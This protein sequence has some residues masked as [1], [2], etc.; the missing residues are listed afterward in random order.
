MIGVTKVGMM[1]WLMAAL[2]TNCTMMAFQPH[3][4]LTTRRATET[5]RQFQHGP[6][7]LPERVAVLETSL[8]AQTETLNQIQGQI[9]QIQG[10]F[11]DLDTKLDTKFDKFEAK[12]EA[13]FD[14]AA[15]INREEFAKVEAKFEAKFDNAALINRAEF[16]NA[17]RINREE[18]A[19]VEAKFDNA[20]LIN[21]AEFAKVE[22]KVDNAALINRA[23]FAK[24]EAKFDNAATKMNLLF[25]YFLILSFS[26]GV[27]IWPELLAMFAK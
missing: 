6:E 3:R 12:F 2:G 7:N 8:A 24:V 5:S 14:N 16:A 9:G 19:K 13:K 17:A 25:I 20:A 15:R 4:Q 1:L 21:R 10:F 11:K 27:K 18:F 23:E 22:A 26:V